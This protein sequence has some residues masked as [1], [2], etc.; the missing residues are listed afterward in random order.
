ML[1]KAFLL[2]GLL[3]SFGANATAT[4]T[5]LNQ[6]GV[7]QPG[8]DIAKTTIINL[9]TQSTA[10]NFVGSLDLV[11]SLMTNQSPGTTFGL[12]LGNDLIQGLTSFDA[13]PGNVYSFEFLNLAAGDYSL[14]FNVNGNPANR[15]YSFTSTITSITPVPEPESYAMMFAGL[16]LVG[17]VAKRRKQA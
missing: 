7:D 9:P 4:V 8:A 16:A 15:A 6:I 14:R 13:L 12:Y 10:F 5:T 17:A 3:V 11:G 2:A 1:G